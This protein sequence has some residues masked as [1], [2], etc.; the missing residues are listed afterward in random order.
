MSF[1]G[2][3][4]KSFLGPLEGKTTAFLVGDRVSNLRFAEAIL[5]LMAGDELGCDLLDLDAFYSSNLNS[6]AARVSPH[7][8]GNFEITIPG[9]G[10]DLESTLASL[11]Q[12]GRGR[13]L[14]IDSVNSLYQLLSSPNPKSS[15][16]KFTFLISALSVWA[17]D[18][19]RAVIASIYER[20]TT[21][22]AKMSRTLADAFDAAVSVSREARGM[23]LR[24]ERGSTWRNGAFFLP[25]QM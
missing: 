18:N 17:R 1:G 24:C 16:R 21:P 12:E 4:T 2:Q 7:D 15:S 20:R 19:R 13:T 11:F 25:F 10:S 6:I 3:Q 9:P 22:R 14:V 23:A 5:P 8:M